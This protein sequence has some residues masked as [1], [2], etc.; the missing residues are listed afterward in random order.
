M[1]KRRAQ[2]DSTYHK[3][4]ETPPTTAPIVVIRDI[5]AKRKYVYD[6]LIQACICHSNSY[7]MYAARCPGGDISTPSTSWGFI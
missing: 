2:Y 7:S 3:G 6:V 1:D 4:S 5:K